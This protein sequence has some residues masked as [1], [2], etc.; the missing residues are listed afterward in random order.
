MWF[1][2]FTPA[3]HS[4]KKPVSKKELRKLQENY[5][6][7]DEISKKARELEENEQKKASQ[8]FDDL[9]NSID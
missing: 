1:W 9:L 8:E 4:Y 5:S 6:K 3:A 2:D 7:A